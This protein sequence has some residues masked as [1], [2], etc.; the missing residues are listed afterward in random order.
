MRLQPPR[1]AR[2]RYIC[3]HLQPCALR[4]RTL[5]GV[6][7][8]QD[9]IQGHIQ[10]DLKSQ[11]GDF[12]IRRADGY[13]AYQLAVVVDDAHQHISNIVRGADLLDSTPR[14]IWLQHC[15][16]LPTP[17]YAHIPLITQRDGQKLSKRLQ[18]DPLR[19]LKPL[20]TLRLALKFL[21]QEPPQLEW[22]ETW[23]WALANWSLGKIPR[24][25]PQ[26]LPI[27]M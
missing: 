2:I 6:I 15:L 14:Q 1:I 11:S 25:G 26:S 19:K 18:S 4:V 20:F 3:R 5:E 23:D 7:E 21:G 9:Q 8:F 13:F 22:S 24:V 10:H 17:Q 27:S 16:G 12:V